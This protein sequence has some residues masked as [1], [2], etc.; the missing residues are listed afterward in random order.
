MTESQKI[1]RFELARRIEHVILVISFTTL[2]ITGLVQKYSL[3]GISQGMIYLF[4][5]IEMTRVIHRLAATIFLLESVYHLAIVGYKLFVLR[6]EASMLPGL[7]DAVDGIQ[8]TLYNLGFRKTLPHMGRFNFKEKA[9]YWAL[10]WGL[11]VM[12][13]TGFMMWNPILTSTILPGQFIPAAKAAHGGEAVLAVL[14]IILWHF[15]HVHLRTWNWSMITGKLSRA[16]MEEEHAE[17]LEKIDSGKTVPAINSAQ[18][19]HRKEMYI[20]TAIIISLV[21]VVGLLRFITFEQT[22]L[23]NP[24]T[25]EPGVI[26]F[27][28]QTATPTVKVVATATPTMG[29]ILPT[30]S[31][32]LTWTNGGIA[33][34]FDKSCGACHG[35]AGGLSVTTYADLMKGGAQGIDIIPGDPAG[36]PLVKLQQSGKHPC[37]F[38]AGDLDKV[39]TW[40]QSGAIEK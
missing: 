5:G 16:E 11:F 3:E 26:I 17:E 21:L 15:Y 7:K 12:G 37:L 22:A 19:R 36:S 32:P 38:S 40:I 27:V 28:P 39:I 34:I 35:S 24:P 18:Y 8:E 23:I 25:L 30:P 2:A 31:G 4:G 1:Y 13:A 14:A 29:P 10:I 33:Q 20:P 9:E 6:V